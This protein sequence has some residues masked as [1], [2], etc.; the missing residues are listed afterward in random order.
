MSTA[1]AEPP[2]SSVTARSVEFVA[3]HRVG[4]HE[5]GRAVA[6]LVG[7]P[8]PLAAALRAGLTRMADAEVRTG[9]AFVAPGIGT[10]LG[11]RTP[12]LK[13]VGAGFRAATRGDRSATLLAVADR[14]LRED[15]LE[16]RWLAFGLL[17]RLVGDDPERSWQL[18][19]RAAREAG[20]C[21]TVDTLARAYAWGV[22]AAPFRWA[23]LEQ[24]AFSPSRWERRLVGS[25][26]ATIPH[27]DRR[28]G[29]TSD[30]ATQGLALLARL[31]GDA[32]P[33]VQKALSWAY[34]TLAD[35]DPDATLAALRHEAATAA[36]H[37]DGHR[38]W[39][40]RDTLAKVPPEAAADIRTTLSGVRRSAGA[41]STSEAAA[42][43]ARFGDLPDPRHHPEPPL[44]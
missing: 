8:E 23:E 43:S 42:I 37:G 24:L 2:V 7:E 32:E 33:D 28:T 17:E 1:T 29:R 44:G 27:A 9:Q 21:I 39:V 41:P 36:G 11:I 25:T 14:L 4:A 35:V 3:A 34:R 16:A 38:A 13:A 6:D 30:V 15:Y 18:M 10:T 31:I 20:D 22:L 12:L 26:I 40:V 5:L 19:R